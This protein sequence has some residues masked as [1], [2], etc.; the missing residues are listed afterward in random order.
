MAHKTKII[1]DKTGV[2]GFFRRARVHAQALDRGEV[3]PSETVIAFEDPTVLLRM[4]TT[5]KQRL[6]E[7]L[8][9]ANPVSI[10]ALADKLGRN[11]RAVSRDVSLMRH[12]GLLKTKYVTNAG[13][14]RNLVVMPVAKR[15]ELKS[16]I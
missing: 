7:S 10:T 15:I 2:D 9:E 12:Y 16:T 8:R 13:H 3:L 5:E 4:L 1:I 14:G 6:M 11:K